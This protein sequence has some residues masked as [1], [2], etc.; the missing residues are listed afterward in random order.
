M[1][2][3]S[4]HL[5]ERL[6]RDGNPPTAEDIDHAVSGYLHHGIDGTTMENWEEHDPTKP[7]EPEYDT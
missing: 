4:R 6:G 5:V 3:A 2:K 7:P 1:L